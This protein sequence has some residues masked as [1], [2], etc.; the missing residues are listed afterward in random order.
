[1]FQRYR[2][3]QNR[4]TKEILKIP[5][6]K[7]IKNTNCAFNLTF[8]VHSNQTTNDKACRFDIEW[9]QNHPLA[10]ASNLISSRPLFYGSQIKLF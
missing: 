7:R 5:P 2:C 3:H 1:M 10:S 6:S 4:K 8:R 9:N